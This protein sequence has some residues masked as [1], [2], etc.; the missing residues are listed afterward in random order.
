MNDAL[1]GQI[2]KDL[3]NSNMGFAPLAKGHSYPLIDAFFMWDFLSFFLK[4]KFPYGFPGA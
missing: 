4:K 2:S 3:T 1:I